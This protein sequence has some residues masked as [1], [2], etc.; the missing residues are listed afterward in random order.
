MLRA[1]DDLKPNEVY[2]CAGAA[3]KYALWGEL[4]SVCALN[5][6][7]AGAVLHGFSRD[8]RG[9]L[10]L[11]FPCFSLGRYSQDQRARGKILDFRCRVEID[12]VSV[13]PG[14][15]VFGD[16]DGVVIVP[17]EIE[18]EVLTKAWD[19]AHGEKQ[20]MNAIKG[21]LGA[22]EAWEQFGIL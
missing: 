5:R 8:T 22:Q 12:G 11:N 18:S 17:R 2:V 21:G 9:I 10:Q 20:V 3:P 6:G 15:I 16:L 1:L 7:A 14:D 4:M 19:K 13:R